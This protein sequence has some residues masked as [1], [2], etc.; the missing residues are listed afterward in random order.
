[1]TISCTSNCTSQSGVTAFPPDSIPLFTWSATNG[2]WDVNG[3]TDLRAFQSTKSVQP[4][5]G[6]TSIESGGATILSADPTLLGIRTAAPAS[7]S[8]VC[9]TGSW[10]MDTG[11]FYICVSSGSWRRAALSSW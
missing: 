7:S 10:A 8:A 5:A 9:T 6:L 11:Y 1:L 2:T 3:G 4:G